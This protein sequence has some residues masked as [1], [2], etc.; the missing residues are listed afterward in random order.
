[1]HLLKE[2]GFNCYHIMLGNEHMA[3]IVTLNHKRFYIDCGA[4]APIFRPVRFESDYQNVSQF[5]DDK[6]YLLP[7]QPQNH[8]YKYVRYIQGEQSGKVWGFYSDK[9]YQVDDFTRAIKNSY[10][11]GAPF[12]TILRCQLW[13]TERNRSVSLVNNKF[14]IRYSDGNAKEKTLTSTEEIEELIVKEFM[15]PKLPVKEAIDVLKYLNIDV[16]SRDN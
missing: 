16:F 7:V 12:M 4:A 11:S 6:V 10:Q 14:R 8:E 2:I 1:M 5:G 3:I 9:E 13:Q 15:L